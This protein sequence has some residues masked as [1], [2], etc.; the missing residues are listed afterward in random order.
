MRVHYYLCFVCFGITT[1]YCAD[2]DT[3]SVRKLSLSDCVQMAIE[4]NLDVQIDRLN[5][6]IARYNIQMAYAGYE[7]V[8]TMG[9][10]HD[11]SLSPGGYDP[12]LG[13]RYQGSTRDA[14]S[15]ST[16]VEGMLPTGFT[17]KM[18]GSIYDEYGIRPASVP[19]KYDNSRGSASI[20]MSQPLLK[21]FWIDDVRMRIMV[22]KK[23]LKGSELGLRLRMMSTISSVEQ[24]YYDLTYAL[25]NVKVQEKAL[26]LANRLLAENKKRVE[27][28]SMAPLDEKQAESRVAANKSSLL[29]ARQNLII[30]QNV[31]KKLINSDFSSWHEALL[32]PSEPLK[33]IAQV[34]NLQDCWQKGT[35]LRPDLLQSKNELE[36]QDIVLRYNKNQLFPELDLVGSFGYAGAG[37]EFTHTFG[38]IQEMDSP[39]YSYGAT[40]RMP[41]SNR[42]A[43]NNYKIGK[44]QKQQLL[45]QHKKL[46]QDV[47]VQIDDA[48]KRVQTAYQRVD[49]TKQ[50]RLYAEAALDAE[51]KKLENGKSTSFIVLQLQSDLTTARSEEIGALAD[52]NKSIT[53]L[54]LAE[55]SI[56]DK[57]QIKIDIK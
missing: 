24:A 27:V 15:F 2:N 21:N 11:Y 18:S 33:A 25:E 50:A 10:Q 20:T 8:I 7:P 16:G 46:E 38:G 39:Y 29:V 56:L 52:Y 30:Q 36:K 53:Q 5:P 37:A 54:E 17:Y 55:G 9:G 48:V 40:L 28:G 45:L 12:K 22:N 31:L 32:E 13:I 51:Q 26:E 19:P 44:S 35:T 23:S 3:N 49:A 14:N 34:P 47:L 42:A 43:R 41:L 4:H 1:A 6:E 57:H